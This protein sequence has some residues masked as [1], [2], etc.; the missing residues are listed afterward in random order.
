MK[1]D[2]LTIFPEMFSSLENSIIGRAKQKNLISFKATDIRSFSENKHK[3][4]DDTP[5][6]W[7]CRNGDDTRTNL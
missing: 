6:R 4:V 7:W 2:V 5:Y 3:K 1:Y